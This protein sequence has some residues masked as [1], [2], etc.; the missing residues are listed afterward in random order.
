M[1]K[2]L[3]QL[4]LDAELVESIDVESG[5][6]P[7]EVEF[8]DSVLPPD[9]HRGTRVS[10]NVVL[11]VCPYCRN[12]AK[13]VTGRAIYPHRPDL[14]EKRF[15]QCEPCGAHVGLHDDGRPLGSPAREQLRR[16][17]SAAHALF[18][19][20]WRSGRNRGH[21]RKVAYAALAG[22]LGI[23]VEECHIG[24][25]DEQVCQRALVILRRCRGDL[26]LL[27]SCRA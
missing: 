27:R 2:N 17:R 1:S 24:Y 4:A 15:W 21:A 26:S 8:V 22:A 11:V 7:W 10:G 3:S 6:S 9:G 18:D 5:L 12:G 16:M 14:F 25:F 20:I 13:L 19:P 23:P